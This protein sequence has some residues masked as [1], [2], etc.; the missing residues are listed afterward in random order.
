VVKL[1]SSLVTLVDAATAAVVLS[2]AVGSIGAEGVGASVG[3]D[4]TPV[5]EANASGVPLGVSSIACGRRCE[6]LK[7]KLSSSKHL[8]MDPT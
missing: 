3:N 6:T 7:V 4:S 2:L 8:H 1:R 5:E